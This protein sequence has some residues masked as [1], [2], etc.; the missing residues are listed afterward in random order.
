ME[1]TIFRTIFAGAALSL[2]LG[3]SSCHQEE[4]FQSEEAK[5]GAS[6]VVSVFVDDIE[7]V[8]DTKSVLSGDDIETRITDVT[9]AA[10]DNASGAMSGAPKYFSSGLDAM[11][12]ELDFGDQFTVYAVA[13][14][15]DMRSAFPASYSASAMSAITYRIPG[16][17]T[18][19]TGIN[20]RG[21]PM[22]GSVVYNDGDASPVSIPLKRLMAKVSTTL[23]VGW[24]GAITSAK[25]YILNAVL[26]PF[27]V[28]AATSTADLLEEQELS[29][30]APGGVT[31]GEFVFYVPENRQGT[32]DAIINPVDKSADNS[33][34]DAKKN[35]SSY[36]EAVVT[37]DSSKEA[38]GTISY[39]SY[40]GGNNHSDFNIIRNCRY[41]WTV[42]YLP[43]NMQNND[44]K[45]ENDMSWKRYSYTGLSC[46]N[47]IYYQESSQA[48]LN[49][50]RT[51]YTNGSITG[52]GYVSS[53]PS[54]IRLDWQWTPS[55]G[56]VLD[57]TTPVSGSNVLSFT[58]AHPGS[59]HIRVDV[60][61]PYASP[62][63]EKDVQV[64]DFS[65]DIFVRIQ[66]TDYY[67]GDISIPY[68]TTTAVSIGSTKRPISGSSSTQCPLPC[69]FETN[70]LVGLEYPNGTNIFD[71]RTSRSS[72][73]G[74]LA[75]ANITFNQLGTRMMYARS[76]FEDYNS[77]AHT[78]S[79]FLWVT[80]TEKPDL[81]IRPSVSQATVLQDITIRAVAKQHNTAGTETT[82]NL[83]SSDYT[84]SYTCS[85]PGMNPQFA[86]S[87]NNKV[88]TVQKAGT[89]TI[90]LSKNDDTAWAAEPVT[91]TFIDDIS[92]RLGVRPTS[93]TI[94]KGETMSKTGGDFAPVR[95]KWVNN[96]YDSYEAFTG[97]WSWAVKTGYS[98]YV[99]I[100]G[101]TLTAKE[102]GT[103]YV[104]ITTSSS[105]VAY[106]HRTA[107]LEVVVMPD[108]H[109][110]ISV[111]A[112][113]SYVS[114]GDVLPLTAVLTNNGIPWTIEADDLYWVSSSTSIASIAKNGAAGAN[115][116]GVSNGSCTI[117]VY[118]KG[119][120]EEDAK[121]YNTFSVTVAPDDY[122]LTITPNTSSTLAVNDTKTFS[123]SLTNHNI[124]I[125]INSGDLTWVSNNT[126][127]VTVPSSGTTATS[128]TVKAIGAG[129]TTVTVK[130]KT[131]KASATSANITVATSGGG[132][133][134][135][136]DDG[137]NINL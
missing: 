86:A 113:I 46:P 84:F 26:K 5:T 88:L 114:V 18:P 115:V 43:G 107:E 1:R 13:N 34:V 73:V 94:Q 66:G 49:V 37:G 41:A 12:M 122:R 62:Y 48:T 121:A 6:K 16:Y 99:S 137:G 42:T 87:G 56:S 92:Y 44:W 116:T 90:N 128:A 28:S 3:L 50:N 67:S 127:V 91:V 52:S 118:Y 25:I 40:L 112:P 71:Y 97:T 85:D 106:G 21:I 77:E 83:N 89:V 119:M 123:V 133:D 11:E 98:N 39:R 130:Y 78:L 4:A 134:D 38:D 117:T 68:G 8:V 27:G 72:D 29:I 126:S 20:T 15:G 81:I 19:T 129:T 93:V 104:N 80:V 32:I 17:T 63:Y 9:I 24:T 82:V 132:V 51:S 31:S 61:D 75:S 110:E 79:M 35:I 125:P 30:I 60:D 131:N 69:G 10:Y 2:L 109:F 96:V 101:S 95:E 22:A 14:M 108:D 135:G 47:Y 74:K 59:A 120:S 57:V 103:G 100:S 136:W 124:S 76:W 111:T 54:Y 7:D 64:L 55:D 53:L 70:T 36:L 58:G 102:I 105:T 23:S 45:H 33:L 65:R